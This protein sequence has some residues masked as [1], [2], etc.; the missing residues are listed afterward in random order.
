MVALFPLVGSLIV[1]SQPRNRIG[2][3]L[4]AIGVSWA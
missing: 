1:Q 4:I 2:W 3:V